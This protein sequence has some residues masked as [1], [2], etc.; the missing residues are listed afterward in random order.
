M[1]LT[2][3]RFLM[4]PIFGWLFTENRYYAIVVVLVAGLTDMLDGYLA[5]RLEMTSNWGKL[6]DPLADKLLLLTVLFYLGTYNIISLLYFY[7]VLVKESAM[8]IGASILA[9]R[10]QFIGADW[11]GKATTIAFFGAIL[12]IPLELK[13]GYLFLYLAIGLMIAAFISYLFKF[14]HC[15]GLIL[16]R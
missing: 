3:S 1:A 5:R 8:V 2:F 7:L 14:L 11:L 13:F 16:L 10:G 6:L 9:S 15:V 4:I 12:L